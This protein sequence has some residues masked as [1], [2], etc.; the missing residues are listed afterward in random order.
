MSPREKMVGYKTD[1][2]TMAAHCSNFVA[3]YATVPHRHAHSSQF[4]YSRT[5]VMTLRSEQGTWM[6]PP[7]RAVWIPAGVLH[8]ARMITPVSTTTVWVGSDAAI[9]MPN[10]CQV[11]NIS[12]L[13]Q[14][15]LLEVV[16]TAGRVCDDKRRCLIAGLLINE[17]EHLPALSYRLPLPKHPRLASRCRAFLQKPSPHETID[18]WSSDLRMSRRTFTRQF[19]EQTGM[20]FSAWRQQACLVAA[21]PRLANGESVTSVA[22]ELGYNSPAAFTTMFKRLQGVPPSR[23]FSQG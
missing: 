23:C 19:R 16:N 7:E 14:Q 18:S 3:G 12:P 4:V 15:L 1:S 10:K 13:M 11:M 17:L 8:E 9:N 6:V 22:I 20:S 21:L 5:G 2:G